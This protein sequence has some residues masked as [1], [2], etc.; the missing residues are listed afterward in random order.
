VDF[1]G[2]RLGYDWFQD[3]PQS[4]CDNVLNFQA[5]IALPT[6]SRWNAV[7]RLKGF[8]AP[9]DFYDRQLHRANARM[10]FDV[11]SSLQVTRL[12]PIARVM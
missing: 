1:T 3:T 2:G 10:V 6:G 11:T 7:M 5:G 8:V 4:G 9:N 12:W